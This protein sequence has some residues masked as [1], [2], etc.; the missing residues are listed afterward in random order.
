MEKIWAFLG[1]ILNFLADNALKTGKSPKKSE[2]SAEN[3]TFY[4]G[5]LTFAPGGLENWKS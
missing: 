3:P 2:K 1:K 5:G 4:S